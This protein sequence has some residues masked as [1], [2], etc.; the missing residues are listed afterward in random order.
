M[1]LNHNATHANH[2][3]TL[4]L[5]LCSPSFSAHPKVVLHI[6]DG[7]QRSIEDSIHQ[8][9]PVLGISYTSSLEHYLYQVEKFECGVIS[10]IDFD[11][12]QELDAKLEE[13]M[14]S[15]R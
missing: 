3:Q 5:F 15:K 6:T 7:G 11:Y 9:V 2:Q 10:F 13:V 12:Q 14:N 4:T 1:F 8:A